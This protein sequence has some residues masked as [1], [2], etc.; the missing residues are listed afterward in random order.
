MFW[1][2]VVIVSLCSFYGL[3]VLLIIRIIFI[4]PHNS[5]CLAG[6]SDP[7]GVGLLQSSCTQR[8]FASEEN[9]VKIDAGQSSILM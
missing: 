1:W 5:C 7:Q 2:S 9:R 8:H 4:L 6:T 3:F